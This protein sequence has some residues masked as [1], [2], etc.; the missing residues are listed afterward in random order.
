MSRRTSLSTFRRASIPTPFACAVVALALLTAA[1][2]HA[3]LG[4]TVATIDADQAR[5]AGTR[6]LAA[7]AQASSMQ[8]HSLVRDDGSAVHEFVSGAGV[9]FAIS[10]HTRF[11]P[12][13]GALLG[14]HAPAY[15][16]AA[17]RAMAAPGIRRRVAVE[18]GDLVVEASGHLNAFVGRAYL[19]SMLPA[20]ISADAIR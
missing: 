6:R 17:R 5:I 18:E 2:A 1:P 9:V 8:V 20:G 3:V 16:A 14:V 12:D 13:L 11:K 10:W 15:A 19:K 4:G 7:S